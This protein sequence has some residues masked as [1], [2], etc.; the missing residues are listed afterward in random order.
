MNV[1][2]SAGSPGPDTLLVSIGP[3]AVDSVTSK[4]TF[5]FL[6]V[7]QLKCERDHSGSQ[8]LHIIRARCDART[9]TSLGENESG[10]GM[11]C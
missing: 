7:H 1:V 2:S 4:G 9:C 8:S 3:I 10:T 6:A 5:Y 11:R